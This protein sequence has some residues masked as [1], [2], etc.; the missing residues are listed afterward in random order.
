MNKQE[1]KYAMFG[2]EIAEVVRQ[3]WFSDVVQFLQGK[4]DFCY[5]FCKLKPLYDKYGY[6]E[7]NDFLIIVYNEKN[8]GK[9]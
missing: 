4:T 7:V 8:G 6:K 2:M 5:D 3:Y 9:Q 1:A